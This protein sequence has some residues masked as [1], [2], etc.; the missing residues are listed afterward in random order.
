MKYTV[1]KIGRNGLWEQMYST[2]VL[3]NAL[4]WRKTLTA[5]GWQA[6]IN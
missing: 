5:L 1:Y 2:N 6:K 4:S 3:A